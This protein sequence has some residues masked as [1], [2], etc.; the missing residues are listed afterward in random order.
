MTQLNESGMPSPTGILLGAPGGIGGG[1][2]RSL[3]ADGWHVVALGRTEKNL[4]ALAD[5]LGSACEYVVCDAYDAAA[6]QH[7]VRSIAERRGRIDGLVNCV[8][9]TSLGATDGLLL[10]TSL[11]A[12][13]RS[14]AS[15]IRAYFAAI[16]A[17][18]PTMLQAGQGAIVNIS[19]IGGI[20]GDRWLTA[21]QAAKA[22]I[23]QLS[24]SVAAQ[25]GQEGV[26]CNTVV[27]GII[28]HERVEQSIGEFLPN[29]QKLTSSKRL[30]RPDDVGSL[31]AFLL[32]AKSE[33]I[34]GE[35]IV[36]DGGMTSRA[37]QFMGG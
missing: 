14:F 35:A 20:R 37:P 23:I 2:C 34:N 30:G 8:A 26:R 25:Y 15:S 6:V 4:R 32:S 7:A 13:D 9:D 1:I 19:S 28:V 18:L 29:A 31:V 5:E 27:P 24:R 11:E 33:F 36:C 17:A 12:W 3:V 22:G 10:D 16:Q 21:Y